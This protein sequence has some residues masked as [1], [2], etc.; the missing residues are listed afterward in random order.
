[1]LIIYYPHTKIKDKYIN[2][3]RKTNKKLNTR[4]RQIYLKKCPP[5]RP[6]CDII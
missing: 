6:I 4:H 3:C 1:M 5:K 2:I